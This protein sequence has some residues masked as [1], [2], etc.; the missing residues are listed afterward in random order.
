MTLRIPHYRSALLAIGLLICALCAFVSCAETSAQHYPQITA[1]QTIVEAMRAPVFEKVGANWTEAI[2]AILN[3]VIL[4]WNALT[5]KR[6][7]RL[8]QNVAPP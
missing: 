8:E 2:L 5:T 7:S 4:V 1:A 3:G 6:L